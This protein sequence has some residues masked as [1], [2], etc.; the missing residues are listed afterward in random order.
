MHTSTAESMVDLY[1]IPAGPELD[2]LVHEKVFQS[3]PSHEVPHYSSDEDLARQVYK[4]L[5]REVDSSIVM[6]KTRSSHAKRYFA[7]YGTDPSTST[8]VLAESL[9]LAICRMAVLRLRH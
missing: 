8:E 1:R 3:A 5:K 7:R 2:R 4:Q 6:G 9:P